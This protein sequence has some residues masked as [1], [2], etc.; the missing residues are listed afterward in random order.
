MLGPLL[1]GMY[2]VGGGVF[3]LADLIY[4]AKNKPLPMGVAIPQVSL[5]GP[6]LGYGGILMMTHDRPGPGAAIL[7][8]S[9]W[10]SG[11]GG[12]SLASPTPKPSKPEVSVVVTPKQIG[13][14][15]SGTF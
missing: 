11:Y 15:V 8:T 3:L 7:A 1:G 14:Q 5:Y 2:A 12:Y 10:F 13:A 6:A 4:I 9:L